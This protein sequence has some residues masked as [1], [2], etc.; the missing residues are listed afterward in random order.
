MLDELSFGICH[1]AL[2]S[3][4]SSFCSLSFRI[5]TNWMER[6]NKCLKSYTIYPHARTHTH[7]ATVKIFHVTATKYVIIK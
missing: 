4:V 3:V 2:A 6:C 1:R 5:G 7:K